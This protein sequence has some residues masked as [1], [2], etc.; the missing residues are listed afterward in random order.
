MALA[1]FRA[2]RL[3][4]GVSDT[5]EAVLCSAEN[6]RDAEATEPMREGPFCLGIDLGQNASLSGVAAYWYRSGY[7]EA[8]AVLPHHP[9]LHSRGLADGVGGLYTMAAERGEVYLADCQTDPVSGCGRVPRLPDKRTRAGLQ[10][11]G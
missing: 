9:D 5:L 10:G 6:W 4:Q 3:N 2:L 11:R 1:S 7:C 8:F